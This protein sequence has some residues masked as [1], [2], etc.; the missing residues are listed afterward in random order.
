MAEKNIINIKNTPPNLPYLY[1]LS[2]SYT[3]NAGVFFI[4]KGLFQQ[5]IFI[6]FIPIDFQIFFNLV[7]E[8]IRIN[9]FLDV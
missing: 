1:N 2:F 3:V 9:T 5:E 4:F 8:Q 6:F 7:S